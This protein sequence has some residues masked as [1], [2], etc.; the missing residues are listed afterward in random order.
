MASKISAPA[1]YRDSDGCYTRRGEMKRTNQAKLAGCYLTSIPP[2]TS[3][4]VA[5]LGI[6]APKSQRLTGDCDAVMRLGR[7]SEAGSSLLL[8]SS[9][10]LPALREA[11]T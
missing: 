3:H 10:P 2:Y 9:S 1:P 5:E 7:V 4:A 6:R 8:Q 11:A